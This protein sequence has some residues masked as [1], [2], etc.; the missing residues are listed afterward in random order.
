MERQG[1][2]QA[3]IR[4]ADLLGQVFRRLRKRRGWTQR[5]LGE[6]A[7]VRQETVSRVENGSGGTELDTVLRL[8]AALGHEV[9]LSPKSGRVSR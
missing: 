3:G 1:G 2:I 7:G 8:C 5:R 9:N 6:E 4:S